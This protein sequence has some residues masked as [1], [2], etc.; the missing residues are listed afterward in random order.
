MSRR[1]G[2]G[3]GKTGRNF[4]CYVSILMRFDVTTDHEL[5][6]EQYLDLPE[7]ETGRR[8]GF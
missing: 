6:F 2:N 3:T 7:P 4:W 1:E 5:S 8:T